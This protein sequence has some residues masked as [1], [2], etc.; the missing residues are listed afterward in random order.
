MIV[1]IDK[2]LRLKKQIIMLFLILFPSVLL[3]QNTIEGKW[4]AKNII[5]YTDLTTYSLVKEKEPNNG[6]SVTFNLDGTFSS[7]QT[8]QCLND[9]F[10]SA[11]GTYTLIDNDHLRMIVENVRSVGLLC[12][13]KKINKKELIR[14]LGVFY[15]YK[16]GENAIQLI[17][18][19]GN[20]QEDKDK[21]LYAQ[22]LS[23]FGAE[24]KLYDYVWNTTNQNEPEGIVKD[25]EDRNKQVN[26]S[27][28]K[29]VSSKNES[30]GNVYLLRE[31]ED[32]YFVVYDS[33]N[34]KVSLAYPKG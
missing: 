20:L 2:V 32:F 22:M 27:N 30:Y 3:A 18:S 6:Y 28:Y 7:A 33:Y 9:C 12:G 29:I 11:S 14:D 21:M 31:K 24:W 10:V 15:I 1:T 19:N 26:L 17:P 34:K 5:G 4:I 8:M 23:S 25:C 13:M 16:E